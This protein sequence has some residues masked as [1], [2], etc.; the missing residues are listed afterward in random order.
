LYRNFNVVGAIH[1]LPLHTNKIDAKGLT[2]TSRKSKVRKI[3]GISNI[4]HG[5]LNIEQVFMVLMQHKCLFALTSGFSLG[6]EQIQER[7]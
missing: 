1:E 4:F 3:A 2:R 5:V 7:L 6:S